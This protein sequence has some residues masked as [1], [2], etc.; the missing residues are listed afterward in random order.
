MTTV[1]LHP[2]SQGLRDEPE[3]VPASSEPHVRLSDTACD[4]R[5]RQPGSGIQPTEE[6]ILRGNSPQSRNT[7]VTARGNQI[8]GNLGGTPA[9]RRSES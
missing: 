3:R 2:I 8:I 6:L 5:F 7:P 4:E 9:E 1:R